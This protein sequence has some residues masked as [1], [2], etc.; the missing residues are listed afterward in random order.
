MTERTVEVAAQFPFRAVGLHVDP[1]G[2][3][4]TS[5]SADCRAWSALAL[6]PH[7]TARDRDRAVHTDTNPST[8]LAQ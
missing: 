5:P 8:C 6:G 4:Y 3:L 7:G 1:A 2:M